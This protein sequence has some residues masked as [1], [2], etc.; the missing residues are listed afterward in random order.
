MTMCYDRGA[1][2]HV[3][4]YLRSHAEDLPLRDVSLSASMSSGFVEEALGFVSRVRAVLRDSGSP[5]SIWNLEEKC[6]LQ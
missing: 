4:L 1:H 2:P 5:C 6:R 3:F